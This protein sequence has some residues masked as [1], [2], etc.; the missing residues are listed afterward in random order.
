MAVLLLVLKHLCWTSCL[1]WNGCSQKYHLL[2]VLE[3]MV[4]NKMLQVKA[5]Y[6]GKSNTEVDWLCCFSVCLMYWAV[7]SLFSFLLQ[8]K[9]KYLPHRSDIRAVSRVFWSYLRLAQYTSMEI[10]RSK[11]QHQCK[12]LAAVHIDPYYPNLISSL[13][14]I[15]SLTLLT[16]LKHAEELQLTYRGEQSQKDLLISAKVCRWAK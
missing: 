14:R 7:E 9:D 11:I 4:L 12:W 10:V 5:L 15:C 2:V 13:T 8:R 6:P 1:A 16:F 3:C